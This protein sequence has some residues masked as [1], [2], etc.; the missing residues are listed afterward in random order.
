[1]PDEPA[2]NPAA[3]L[4]AVEAS[5]AVRRLADG[6]YEGPNVP[7]ADYDRLFGGQLLAQALGAAS[8]SLAGSEAEAMTP[9]SLHL[10]FT[11]EGRPDGPVRW[12]VDPVHTGRTFATRSVSALQGDRL[13]V[14]GLVSLHSDEEGLDHQD[15]APEVAAPESLAPVAPSGAMPLEMRVV[16]DVRLDGDE[17]GPPELDVWMRTPR[18]VGDGAPLAQQQ[19]LAYCSDATM[20]AAAMRPHEGLG[21]GSSL[22]KASA[23]TSQTVSF[24]RPFVFSDWLLFAQRSP[25]AFRARAYIQGDWYDSGGALVASSAQEAL[26]RTAT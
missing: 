1:M 8:A 7:L 3:L 15:P 17:V 9:R 12:T 26:I 13:L 21:F 4:D 22:L 19:L 2:V 24:H 6:R 18:P 5:F 16:G 11:S 10:V 25:S 20:M 14:T 23:V